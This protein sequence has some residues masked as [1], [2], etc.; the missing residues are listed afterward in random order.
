MG[1]NYQ[2]L[3]R[4]KL[5]GSAFPQFIALFFSSSL[6]SSG[7]LGYIGSFFCWL[8]SPRTVFFT[9]VSSRAALSFLLRGAIALRFSLSES[10]F[11]GIADI[12]L[13]FVSLT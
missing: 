12:A 9:G 2:H 13:V 6:L 5:K 7:E 3:A 1:N 10:L 8:D 11:F 4:E